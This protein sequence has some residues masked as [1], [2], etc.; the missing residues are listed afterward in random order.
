MNMRKNNGKNALQMAAAML[1]GAYAAALV[2]CPA[3]AAEIADTPPTEVVKFAD[4]NISS[5]AGAAALYRRIHNA[6][7][8]V[9]GS[10]DPRELAR[11]AVVKACV[12]HAVT[13]ALVAVNNPAINDRYLAKTR[14]A[15]LHLAE[16]RRP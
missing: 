5:H 7:E 14:Q 8:R 16:A 3:Q 6:A 13:E 15:A 12:D 2:A 10:V 11:A 1:A 9:C 4:L